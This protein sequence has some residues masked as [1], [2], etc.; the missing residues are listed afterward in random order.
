ML[1]KAFFQ[2]PIAHRTLHDIVDGRPENSLAG[3]R[4]A[5]AKGYGIEIDLQPSKDGVPMVFH[6]YSLERLT[7]S[8]GA[9]AQHTAAELD[10]ISLNQG[11]EGIPTL[12]TFLAAVD[13]RV[14]LLIEIKDQDGAL[15]ANVGALEK[16]IC[17]ILK[18]YTG[19]AALMSFNPHA[20]AKCA[21]FAPD[22][23]RGLVTGPFLADDWPLVPKARRLELADIPDYDR[24][25]ACFISHQVKYLNNARVAR[26]KDKG[27]AVFCWTVRS[28]EQE[29][30][31]RSVAQNITF[32]G[33]LA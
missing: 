28:V 13:G 18:R 27:A 16:A 5:I 15:G 32:E 6:D 8:I 9:V 19:P 2:A 24:V 3:A 12:E 17:E 20:I 22:I 33:Y 31:A 14:P 21:Q 7:G 11:D 4:A 26:L 25:G 1:A 23:A 29:K 30:T 10:N